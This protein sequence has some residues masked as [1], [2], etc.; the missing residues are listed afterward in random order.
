MVLVDGLG[1]DRDAAIRSGILALDSEAG[2]RLE[3]GA[4]ARWDGAA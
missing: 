4:Y 3:L 2:G 1:L